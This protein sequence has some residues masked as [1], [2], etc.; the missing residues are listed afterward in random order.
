MLTL[1]DSNFKFR[2]IDKARRTFGSKEPACVLQGA[3]I[4]MQGKRSL[5]QEDF[6][7][8]WIILAP[9]VSV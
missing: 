1:H 5:R 2:V 6:R 8:R 3:A 4:Y 9:Y 7:R